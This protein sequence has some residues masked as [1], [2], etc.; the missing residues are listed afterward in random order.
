[1]NSKVGFWLRRTSASLG[2][3]ASLNL[4]K[5]SCFGAASLPQTCG[6]GFAKFPTFEFICV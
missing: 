3:P 1:M 2:P 6:A 4:F 5:L